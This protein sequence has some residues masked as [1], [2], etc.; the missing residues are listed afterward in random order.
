VRDANEAMGTLLLLRKEAHREGREDE[1]ARLLPTSDRE[2]R[3]VGGT[4]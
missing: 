2:E 4:G 1:A 3:G